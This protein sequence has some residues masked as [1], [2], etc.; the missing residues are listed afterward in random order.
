MLGGI[1]SHIIFLLYWMNAINISIEIPCYLV[2]RKMFLDVCMYVCVSIYIYIYLYI[3]IYIY[4]YLYIYLY[5]SLSL[6]LSIY[7]YIYVCMY[8]YI[9]SFSRKSVESI[10]I[11]F[12]LCLCIFLIRKWN[13]D[14]MLSKVRQK[15]GHLECFKI[16]RVF[17]NTNNF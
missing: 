6:S 16:I 9:Y 5:I 13:V 1:I 14:M 4:I 3:Y 7:I 2:Y 10:R 17:G 15:T 12:F 8:V 11:N